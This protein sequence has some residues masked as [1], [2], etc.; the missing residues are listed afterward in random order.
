MRRLTG[1]HESRICSM[2]M[3]RP[4][5]SKQIEFQV[6]RDGTLI[7]SR[8]LASD[9]RWQFSEYTSIALSD[10]HAKRPDIILTDEDVVIKWLELGE[11]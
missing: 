10:F 11:D 5:S 8:A 9:E 3:T 4:E 2:G 7:F 1:T 6:L